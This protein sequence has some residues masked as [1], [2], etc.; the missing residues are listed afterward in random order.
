MAM[1]CGTHSNE[2]RA[3]I[4]WPHH[5][6]RDLVCITQTMQNMGPV[7]LPRPC[8]LGNPTSCEGGLPKVIKQ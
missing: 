4:V 5:W 3:H 7:K 2:R 6:A 1:G 8:G